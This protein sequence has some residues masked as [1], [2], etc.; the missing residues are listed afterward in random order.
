MVSDGKAELP[1]CLACIR[2]NPCS[3]GIWSLTSLSLLISMLTPG[4]NPCSNGICCSN[5]IWSLTDNQTCNQ[6][7]L[8]GLNPCSNGI[9]SLTDQSISCTIEPVVRS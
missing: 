6:L 2:L 9:W 3:N 5:G 7:L 4:L 8:T 1:G